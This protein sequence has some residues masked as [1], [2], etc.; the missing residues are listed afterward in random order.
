MKQLAQD[1]HASNLGGIVSIPLKLREQ[2]HYFEQFSEQ[3]N[4]FWMS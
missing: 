3:F 2:F 4:F 1:Q